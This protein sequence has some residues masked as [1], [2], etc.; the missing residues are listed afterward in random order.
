MAYLNS[1]YARLTLTDAAN[2]DN[3][4]KGS[5]LW[6]GP[7][8]IPTSA[9]LAEPFYDPHL[10]FV[11]HPGIQ[12]YKNN[13]TIHL[14][15]VSRAEYVSLTSLVAGLKSTGRMI[16]IPRPAANIPVLIAY[17]NQITAASM[18]TASSAATGYPDDNLASRAL[19]SSWRSATAALSGVTL[20]ADLG[21]SSDIDVFALL[22]SN[23]T[24]A[25]TMTVKAGE[26]STF[27]TTEYDSG[28]VSC[29]DTT[30]S[31]SVL[32]SMTPRFG[33]HVIWAPGITQD[34]GLWVYEGALCT[35]DPDEPIT[36]A[37]QPTYP[38]T[39]VTELK[40][41]MCED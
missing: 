12:I 27:A 18:V 41:R 19:Y 38:E 29:F 9:F 30:H 40:F 7:A 21:A 26:S 1:R 22:G 13:L 15:G 6:V 34:R 4:L 14:A 28:S 17:Q 20:T 2:P 33:R 35:W 32:Q 25:A 23:L 3:Y 24:D 10:E 31:A 37:L 36:R 39:W 5:V 8:F 11:G 16:V